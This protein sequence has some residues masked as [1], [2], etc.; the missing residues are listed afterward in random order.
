VDANRS[1]VHFSE[2]S[3]L[4]V[5]L[6]GNPNS[7][8][9]TLFNALTG[10]NQRTGN[11]P[12]VTVDKKTGTAKLSARTTAEFV[13]LPGTYSLYPKSL[14]ERVAFEVLCDPGNEDHPDVTIIVADAS[15]LKRNL[16]LVSQIIDL[17][18]PVIL[19]L[20]MMDLVEK[21]GSIIDTARLAEKLGVKVVAISARSK[22]GVEALK[23]ALLQP[24][25]IPHFNL[26]DVRKI[27]G[28]LIE[29]VRSIVKVNSDFAA[30][31]VI[32]NFSEIGYFA[33]QPEKQQKLQALLASASYDINKLQSQESLERYKVINRIVEECISRKEAVPAR[34]LTNKL[35]G[36]LT[37]RVWGYFIFLVILFFIFQA[38]FFLAA[39]PMEWIESLFVNI[40]S[41]AE[42][43]LPPG[44]ATDLF[45][46]G[47]LAGLSGVVVFVPQIALLFAFIAILED[48]GYMARVSFIMDKLM[49]KFGLNGRSV[50]PLISGV[51]C[52]VPAIMSARTIS[53]HKERLITIMVTPL[54]SCSARL[55][56]YT[57]LIS[58]IVPQ[59]ENQGFFNY[60]GLIL[61]SLYLIG[62]L[63]AIGAAIVMKWVLKA[64]EKS[65]FIMELPVYRSPQWKT[66]MLT[67]FDKVKVFL[68]DAGKIIIAISIIL[69]YLTSHA[70]GDRFEKIEAAYEQKKLLDQ[71]DTRSFEEIDAEMKSLKLESSYAGII[72][73]TIEPAIEPL[74]FDWKIGISLVTSFAAREVFVGTMATI[75][76]AGQMDN[77]EP[78]REKMRSQINPK[79]GLPV[80]SIAVCFSLMIFYAFAM[81]CMSTLAVVYRETKNWKWPTIQFLYMSAL[82]YLASLLT[83]NLLS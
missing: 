18:I 30:F 46:N 76:S 52:A 66:V 44:E 35:D 80:F 77:T 58:L 27:A 36:I 22:D 69:W 75:Y 24:I 74:G 39:Y 56:V 33:K 50:I 34:S 70:P 4:K 7:G 65:Y 8:K 42:K 62:F 64:R 31:Q 43:L 13:D 5:A 83:Y 79:T 9:S 59:D 38:I 20:N 10:L 54:M 47:I 11:F 55:P 23:S 68:W 45:V 49:R 51:A 73:K 21:S 32:N 19:V 48:T 15:N 17:K 72:G 26:L 81:Q 40:T 1:Y 28:E 12:G 37:H 53:N 63:A 16:F 25:P 2:S 71:N 82:A 29:K 78:I 41:W 60:Q 14:D 61:M 3:T 57:L 67:I 6:V